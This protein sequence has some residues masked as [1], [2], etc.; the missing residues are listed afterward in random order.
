MRRASRQN[1]SAAKP[2]KPKQEVTVTDPLTQAFAEYWRNI[3]AGKNHTNAA[4]FVMRDYGIAM[5]DK[6]FRRC[7]RRIKNRLPEVK[8]L[9]A[10]VRDSQLVEHLV[11]NRFKEPIESWEQFDAAFMACGLPV[12]ML[13]PA[14]QCLLAEGYSFGRTV[15]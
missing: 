2:T 12:G 1:R 4:I 3:N 10:D 6:H 15:E 13:S 14:K 8:G 7:A 9:A 11:R 5:N